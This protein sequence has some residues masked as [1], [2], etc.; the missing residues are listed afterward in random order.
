MKAKATTLVERRIN[1]LREKSLDMLTIYLSISVF[2]LTFSYCYRLSD[3]DWHNIFIIEPICIIVGLSIIYFRKTI[4]YTSLVY[5][6]LALGLMVVAV[7]FIGT[8]IAGGG[9]V[10]S[11]FCIMLSLF[12]LNRTA[13]FAV[14]FCIT[15]IYG[16]AYYKFVYSDHVQSANDMAY[17]SWDS[18][19]VGIYVAAVVFFVL[20]GMSIFHLQKHMFDLL[21]EVEHQ[22]IIIDEQRQRI[23]H[24][25]NHDALTGLP[26]ARVADDLLDRALMRARRS[27]H[28]TAVLFLDLDGFKKIND[29]HGHAAGDEVLKIISE[30]IL[31]VIRSSDK[32]CRIGGDEFLLIADKV[33]DLK[34]LEGLCQRLVTAISSPFNYKK[35]ELSVGVSIGAA[36]Y[37]D[38]ATT[39]NS[40][41][42]KADELMYQVKNSGKN[43]YRILMGE[44]VSI[45]PAKM[46]LSS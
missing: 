27:N 17:M 21:V 6:Y 43:N 7:E 46:V 5:S 41:R 16:Y 14:A 37:P 24:L 15:A 33:D 19:W 26:S 11:L 18:A 1:H 3:I 44:A 36:S 38:A 2:F 35:H 30:R 9:D 22:K 42:I 8:G 29:A 31:S 40:L 39:A 23:E 4:S 45:P 13:T 28:K 25:A 10:A 20:I 32:A 12:Y 34:D